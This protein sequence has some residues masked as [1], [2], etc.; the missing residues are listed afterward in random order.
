[1]RSAISCQSCKLQKALMRFAT[2][3]FAVLGGKAGSGSDQSFRRLRSIIGVR[4][5]SW[6]F[7]LSVAATAALASD[8]TITAVSR[9]LTPDYVWGFSSGVKQQHGS[10]QN[11]RSLHAVLKRNGTTGANGYPDYLF[12][13]NE[14][15]GQ[16]IVTERAAAYPTLGK[17]P[18]TQAVFASDASP[19]SA[20][21]FWWV[22]GGRADSQPFDLYRSIAPFS[23]LLLERVL[24]DFVTEPQSTTPALSVVGDTGLIPYRWRASGSIKG[25]VRF[26]N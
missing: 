19:G 9:D 26:R 20:G 25:Q 8:P 6:V 4:R 16:T 22:M 17:N 15:T 21:Y 10:Y 5:I 7:A 13:F 12:W 23:P 1:M 3:L 24:D 18:A 14:H 11:G 2:T